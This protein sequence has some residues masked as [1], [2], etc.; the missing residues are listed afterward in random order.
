MA[1]IASRDPAIKGGVA[2]RFGIAPRN[3]AK[4]DT[5]DEAAVEDLGEVVDDEIGA[6][7]A[8]GL[9]IQTQRHYMGGARR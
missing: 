1:E 8:K 5:G 2:F 7:R 4:V 9:V 3:E 6:V